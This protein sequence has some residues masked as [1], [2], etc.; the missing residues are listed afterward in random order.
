[1]NRP[2]I[3]AS[4]YPQRWKKV[5]ELMEHHNLDALITYSDDR[6]TYGAAYAR[7]LADFHTHFEPVLLLFDQSGT[8]KLLCGPETDGYAAL[9][10][11]I[12]EIKVLREF[13]HPDEDYPF[14]QVVA[15]SDVLSGSIKRLGVAGLEYMGY[16]LACRI[17]A[18]CDG[19]I[20]DVSAPVSMLRAVKT[21]AEIEVIRYAYRIAQAG[22]DA[23]LR[24]IDVG[25]TQRE[26][27]AAAECAM[28]TMGSEGMGIDTIIASGIDGRPILARTTH[29][30]IQK[31]D[32][33]GV[34]LAPRYE[35]YHGA[36]ARPIVIGQPQDAAALRSI[37]AQEKAQKET[38]HA[39]Q[40][41]RCGR[42]AEAVGR[43]IMAQAGCEKYFLYSGIHSIGVI[44]FEA[45]IFGPSSKALL[46]E[47]MTV[48]IDIPVYECPFVGSRTEDGYLILQ[49]GV[50]RLNH[51][52]YA[53]FK[54]G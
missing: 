1:M 13:C 36:I 32:I 54:Q 15:L 3:P 5:Y 18:A 39:L 33:V 53:I 21:P 4:E 14:T 43:S 48:S 25:V 2:I 46:H 22:F 17:Q 23:A 41:G 9:H 7:W 11:K 42:D 34:T 16:P 45:P 49:N 31:N 28:R 20:V 10:S 24:A 27:A 8:P 47:N 6:A 12:Q 40:A 26:V 30:E 52:P 35:G 29:H 38:A 44:E 37:E 51:T 50:E 19:E